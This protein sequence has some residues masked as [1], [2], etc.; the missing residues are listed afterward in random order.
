M[1]RRLSSYHVVHLLIPYAL[2]RRLYLQSTIYPI[3]LL[4]RIPFYPFLPSSGSS[5]STSQPSASSPG[6]ESTFQ[7]LCLLQ[8]VIII[9]DF[10]KIS[11]FSVVP[12]FQRWGIYIYWTCDDNSLFFTL[13]WRIYVYLCRT[14]G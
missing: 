13:S 10:S 12:S 9:I 8:M 2:L 14:R 5:T 11:I 3:H 4:P 7:L 1:Q 6:I